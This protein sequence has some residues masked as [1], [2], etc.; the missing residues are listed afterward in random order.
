MKIKKTF[1]KLSAH[2]TRDNKE[3]EVALTNE[4]QWED[5]FSHVL[6][7]Q[8][9]HEM[10]FEIQKQGYEIKEGTSPVIKV[11][12]V[13]KTANDYVKDDFAKAFQSLDE[14]APAEAK[15]VTAP[16]IQEIDDGLSELFGNSA[17][18]PEAEQPP[19]KKSRFRI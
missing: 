11:T 5:D 17:K 7:V 1:I 16:A 8:V 4:L 3:I 19:A 2:C 13:E 18:K 6:S 9:L 12:D 10:F 14:V 15:N